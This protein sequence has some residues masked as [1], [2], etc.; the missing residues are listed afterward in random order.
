MNDKD[1]KEYFKKMEEIQIKLIEFI[2]GGSN[3]ENEFKDLISL[4]DEQKIKENKHNLKTLFHLLVKITDNH[5]RSANF[6][7][8]IEQILS[9]FQDEIKQN[10]SNFDIFNIFK[11]NKRILLFLFER[12]IITPDNSISN[13]ITN[14]K[15]KKL[16]YP[17]FFFPEFKSF[18]SEKFCQEINY[19]NREN[20]KNSEL[21]EI[22]RKRGENNSYV[23]EIIRNDMLLF[24]DQ[25]KY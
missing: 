24:L 9:F 18:F 4:F 8:K 14:A 7:D 1:I 3:N 15:Y 19:I 5:H 13:I 17:E 6:F 21:F 20:Q 2:D 11:S 23:T 22:N 16:K 25:F 12:Q 10:F